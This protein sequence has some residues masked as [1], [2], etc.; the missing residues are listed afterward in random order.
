MMV[1]FPRFP[2]SFPQ[3]RPDW[4]QS[5]K[6]ID[7]SIVKKLTSTND[8]DRTEAKVAN[9]IKNDMGK[10]LTDFGNTVRDSTKQPIGDIDCGMKDVLIEVK[11]SVNNVKKK[12]IYKYINYDDKKFINVS[13]K[14]VVLYIDEPMENISAANQEKLQSIE[15]M[16]VTI[17]NGLEELK[18]VL[19]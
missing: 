19:E 9:F 2:R 12:Q 7:N 8:G 6:D 1:T 17:V 11:K 14:K 18:G 4:K 16:G 3:K 10:E 5:R 13:N 15:E